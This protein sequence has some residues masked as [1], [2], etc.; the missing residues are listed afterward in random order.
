[1]SSVNEM[2]PESV[3][4]DDLDISEEEMA[5]V[6]STD[7]P[8]NE[9]VEEEPEAEVEA[10]VEEAEEE[11]EPE[12]EEPVEGEVEDAEE[13]EEDEQQEA[14]RIPKARFDEVN[15]KAKDAKA[16][17]EELRNRIAILEKM[18]AGQSPQEAT[19]Q[20]E[21]Q[22]EAKTDFDFDA[23]EEAYMEAVL[24]GETE[25][26]KA[27]RREIREAEASVFNQTAENKSTEATQM[28]Q[29][30]QTI[31][32]EV[33]RIN[34]EQP[35]FDPQSDSFNQEALEYA[36]QIRDGMMATGK[37]PLAAINEGVR[38]ATALYGTPPK[39]AVQAPKA[40]QEVSK[41]KID[42]A[43]KQPPSIGD[44]ATMPAE[45]GKKIDVMNMSEDE[46][47]S[48]SEEELQKLLAS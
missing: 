47:D 22:P 34:E 36:L 13:V 38:V 15:Q 48:L 28:A 7:E 9:P 6:M 44:K 39:P 33:S 3:H 20:P 43:N 23:K 19:K 14:P 30:E 41:K 25:L 1:M 17:A 2:V 18:A 16:E 35:I 37:D 11:E 12:A 46:F 21:Q 31:Q 42:A 32:Q 10:D 24:D 29:L 8:V 4:A 26:A 5:A 27:L 40:K 45:S